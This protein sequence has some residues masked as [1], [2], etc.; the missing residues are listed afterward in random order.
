MF[1]RPSSNISFEP[2]RLADSLA[3]GGQSVLFNHLAT[4]NM[5]RENLPGLLFI[6]VN[7]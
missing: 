4:K 2:G 6:E 7:V 1:E 3:A 5:I